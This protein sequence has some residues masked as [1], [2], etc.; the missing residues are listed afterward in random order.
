MPILNLGKSILYILLEAGSGLFGTVKKVKGQ[1][2]LHLKS[3]KAKLFQQILKQFIS[4][5]IYC[6]K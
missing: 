3:K 1:S 2:R 6:D 4:L 5:D